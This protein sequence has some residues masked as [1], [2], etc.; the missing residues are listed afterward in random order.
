M[1]RKQTYDTPVLNMI[2]AFNDF[3]GGECLLIE[4][5][6]QW[7]FHMGSRGDNRFIYWLELAME[8]A[9]EKVEVVYKRVPGWYSEVSFHIKEKI[10]I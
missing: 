5:R 8:I 1:R 3:A 6:D 7:Y 9:N 2:K 10:E 4:L